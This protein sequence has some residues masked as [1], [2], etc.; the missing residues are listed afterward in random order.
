MG[1]SVWLYMWLLDKVTSVDEEGTG[2]VLGGRPI[3]Y[4]E[5]AEELGIP[6][7][8]YRRWIAT[9]KRYP[10]ITARRSENGLVFTVLKTY[11]I[12][13]K[14][15]ATSGASLD[16]LHATNGTSDGP[17]MAHHYICIDSKNQLDSKNQEDNSTNVE[18]TADR[19]KHRVEK[20]EKKDDRN[21]EVQAIL[22]A[23]GEQGRELDMT[24]KLQRRYAY[25]IL[26]HKAK[27]D[28]ERV[29]QVV[30]GSTTN[31]LRWLYH[32]FFYCERMS[33]PMY[34]KIS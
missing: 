24:H 9:L 34:I 5:V 8:T 28:L 10:Y 3:K 33:K 16:P 4:E 13:K 15:S 12:F 21:K 2:K 20:L 6:L 26:Q 22:D 27:G 17:Q 23:F 31:N 30:R 14:R 1:I 11:K 18:L 32:N 7:R 19:Q 29:L 25:M